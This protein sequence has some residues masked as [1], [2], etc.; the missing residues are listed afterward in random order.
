MILRKVREMFAVRDEKAL[1]SLQLHTQLQQLYDDMH[2]LTQQING[3]SI[4]LF[5][6]QLYC[7]I[8][9]T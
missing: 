2:H 7:F 3:E 6:V 8:I 1:R 5:F 4:S 9:K